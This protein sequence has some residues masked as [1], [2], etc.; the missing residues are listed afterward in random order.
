MSEQRVDSLE[1]C[2]ALGCLAPP[3]IGMRFPSGTD[4]K[5]V[6]PYCCAHAV[7]VARAFGAEEAKEESE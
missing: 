2:A 1:G 3:V 4:P 5:A 6:A 7:V